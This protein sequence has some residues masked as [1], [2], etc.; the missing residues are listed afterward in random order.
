MV[1][2]LINLL[3][4]SCIIKNDNVI[5]CI[6]PIHL[7]D[8]ALRVLSPTSCILVPL[9]KLNY[10]FHLKYFF[11]STHSSCSFCQDFLQ[12]LLFSTRL[13]TFSFN[14]LLFLFIISIF[15]FFQT[16]FLGRLAKFIILNYE[17]VKI[18]FD[19][20]KIILLFPPRLFY[21]KLKVN[22]II[23]SAAGLKLL[24]KIQQENE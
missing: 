17:N 2:F 18:K 13:P 1:P 22:I 20:R 3:L 16:I 7:I 24:F 10:L 9:S 11:L 19:Q 23:N 12:F 8:S 4:L 6:S 15:F 14:S 21:R 5:S